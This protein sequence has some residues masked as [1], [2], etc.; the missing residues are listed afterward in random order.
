MAQ[1]TLITEEVSCPPGLIGEVEVLK[2]NVAKWTSFSRKSGNIM[3]T[4][5]FF[6]Y[7]SKHTLE[8]SMLHGGIEDKGGDCLQTLTLGVSKDQEFN[9]SFFVARLSLQTFTYAPLKI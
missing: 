6:I 2:G 8:A 7:W 9:V 1:R 4:K 3:A 5:F